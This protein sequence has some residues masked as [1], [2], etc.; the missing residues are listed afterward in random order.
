MCIRDRASAII[1]MRLRALTGLEYGKLTAERDDLTKLIAHLKDVLVLSENGYGKRTDLDEYR[2]TNRGGKGVKTI[3][4]T[5]K[6]G[7]PVSYTHLD[8]YKRQP[9]RDAPSRT[10]SRSNPTT[11]FAPISTSSA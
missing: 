1:E 9:R 10:S 6:T 7:K 5:E 8:V 2:I 11:R 4:V 3:N